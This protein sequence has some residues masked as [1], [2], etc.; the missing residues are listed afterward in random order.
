MLQQAA[1]KGRLTSCLGRAEALPFAEAAFT[2][3]VAVDTFHHFQHQ[4]GAACEL[5]RVLAPGG[6]LV[7][8]E[9]D[10]RQFPVKLIAFAETLALMRS[11]FRAPAAL[12]RYF[13]S[14][15]THVHVVEERPN[16]WAVVEKLR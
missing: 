7:I 9:P 10:I 4:A 2:K 5:L 15:D 1:D 6:R 11:H 8:E 14:P 13:A 3:I 12:V 16:F